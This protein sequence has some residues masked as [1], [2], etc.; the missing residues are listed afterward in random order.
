MSLSPFIVTCHYHLSLLL[1]STAS[2]CHLWILLHWCI[3]K[4][5]WDRHTDI[6]THALWRWPFGPKN[7]HFFIKQII[8]FHPNLFWTKTEFKI[9]NSCT[10]TRFCN[11]LWSKLVLGKRKS[12]ATTIASKEKILYISG[13][14]FFCFDLSVE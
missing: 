14:K 7:N 9:K 6:L 3:L 10:F 5:F 1:A 2:Q 13:F 4:T 12:Y 11:L 8:F